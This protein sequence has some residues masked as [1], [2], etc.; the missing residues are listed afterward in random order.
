MFF[1]EIEAFND[2]KKKNKTEKVK[3]FF[4]TNKSRKKY[5]L[6]FFGS[7]KTEEGLQ[8]FLELEK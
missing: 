2:F 3:R 8:E 1:F 7:K 5:R 6:K 4:L